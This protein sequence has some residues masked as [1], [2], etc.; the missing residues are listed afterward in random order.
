MSEAQR[1]CAKIGDQY[2]AVMDSPTKSII[3]SRRILYLPQ[4]TE[5]EGSVTYGAMRVRPFADAEAATMDRHPVVL[6][7]KLRDHALRFIH[8]SFG[9]PGYTRLLASCHLKYWWK[10]MT[11]SITEYCTKCQHC[12]LRKSSHRVSLPPLQGYPGVTRPF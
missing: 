6:P 10:G 7:E 3:I 1:Q 2:T 5:E 9:H 12:K 4:R 11:K 8:D